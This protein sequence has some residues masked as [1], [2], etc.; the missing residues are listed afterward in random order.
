MTKISWKLSDLVSI[1][2]NGYKVFSCFHCGGGSSMG[3]KLAGFE[4]LGG[5]EIDSAMLKLYQRNLKPKYYYMTDIV[6]FNHLP[7]EE[8]PQELFEL[9]ILDGSPPC[10]SFSIAGAREKKWGQKSKF[11]EGQ[12]EQ[13]LDDLFFHFVDTVNKLKPKIVI[14]ENVKGLILGKAKGYVKQIFQKFKEAGYN[15]QLFLLDSSSMGVPQKRQRTF[16]IAKRNDLNLPVLQLNFNEK[17]ISV[18]EAFKGIASDRS[19]IIWVTENSKALW[20][21]TKL[22]NSFQTVHPNANGFNQKKL[23][24]NKPA[25]T[26]TA[27]SVPMHWQEPR[28][29]TIEEA[30]RL[31]TFPDDYD[32]VGISGFYAIGM[33][34]PPFMMQR[35]ANEIKIQWL[36][37][38]T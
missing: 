33:S 27:S 10:S 13:I 12:K 14:A 32:F 21:K 11:R 29:I 6:S 8:L 5:V 1:P 24:P 30:I 9:D 22:G 37:K 7:D 26:L 28:R 18:K 15:T 38:I 35:L 36:D 31:Q 3:Y 23:N 20:Q 17:P 4:A 34:V 25:A 16:F 19:K 2:A